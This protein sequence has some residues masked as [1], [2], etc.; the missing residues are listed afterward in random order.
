DH[1]QRPLSFPNF[2]KGWNEVFLGESQGM[3]E[4]LDGLKPQTRL[5][6]LT[7]TNQLHH[8]EWKER[9]AGLFGRL[10]DIFVSSELG[11][12]K[13]EPRIFETV[14]EKLGIMKSEE[15]IF[16]DDARVNV[17]GAKDSGWRAFQTT[18]CEQIRE[19]LS[20]QTSLLLE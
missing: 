10:E 6:G 1:F 4:L 11:C 13:P 12:R 2:I 3:A 7:N 5:L 9:Y 16:F 20:T 17:E 14:Q 8:D 18:S 19:H 15:I